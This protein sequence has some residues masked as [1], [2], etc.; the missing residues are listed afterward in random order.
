MTKIIFVTSQSINRLSLLIKSIIPNTCEFVIIN[1]K[2]DLFDNSYKVGNYDILI[3]FCNGI[4]I[5]ANIISN[6]SLAVNF[7]PAPPKYPG[8]DVHHF[9]LYNSEK[10]YGA[11]MHQMTEKVDDG[12]IIKTREFLIPIGITPTDLLNMAIE[13]SYILLE[14]NLIKIIN[15]ESEIL[16]PPKKIRWGKVKYTRK[17][18]KEFCRIDNI[19]DTEEFVKRVRCFHVKP[20]ENIEVSIDNKWFS[21]RERS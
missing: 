11:T 3:S 15:R 5:P 18:F 14:E 19:E 2:S 4:I 16:D 21:L 12:K 20:Y 7:H 6:L 8:R 9:A 10:R 17:M 1:N 13:E